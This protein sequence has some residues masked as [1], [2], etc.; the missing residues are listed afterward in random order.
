MQKSPV[1][2]EYGF[3]GIT[4][5]K[6]SDQSALPRS[7]IRVFSVLS[8]WN[9]YSKGR[10]FGS[11]N[12]IAR[13]ARVVALRSHYKLFFLRTSPDFVSVL[14]PGVDTFCGQKVNKNM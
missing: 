9:L 13:L 2:L 14:K 6:Y 10:G 11:A 1:S 12:A 7:L 4:N 8:S 5:K 3:H